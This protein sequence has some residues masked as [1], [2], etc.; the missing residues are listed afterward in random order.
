MNRQAAQVLVVDDD[1]LTCRLI[2][3]LLQ[4]QGYGAI[5]THDPQAALSLIQNEEPNLVLL[6][7]QLPKVDGFTVMRHLKRHRQNLPVIML[8]AKAEMADR[9]TGLEA[10]ADDYIVKPFEPAELLARVKAV[11]RR[12]QRQLAA[13]MD[14]RVSENGV[15]LDVNNLSATLPDGEVVY[16]TPMETRILHRL[17]ANPN[18]VVSRDDLTNYAIR[19][20]EDTSNNRIDVYVGRIRRKLGDDPNDPRYIATVR[21]S[22]YKFLSPSRLGGTSLGGDA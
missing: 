18:H 22:G 17:M 19:Y 14:T 2:E 15:E 12:S 21:G 7:V 11:L 4:S 6:D 5:V 9:L 16:L 3:F 8:T 1:P 13:S 10:G 20:I